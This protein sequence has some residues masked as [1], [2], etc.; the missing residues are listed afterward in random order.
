MSSS[1]QS[2]DPKEAKAPNEASL[3]FLRSLSDRLAPMLSTTV[4]LSQEQL[5]DLGVECTKLDF[6]TGEPTDGGPKFLHLAPVNRMEAIAETDNLVQKSIVRTETEDVDKDNYIT[7]EAVASFFV[8]S[9]FNSVLKKDNPD[10]PN[11]IEESPW[12]VNYRYH[13]STTGTCWGT[14]FTLEVRDKSKPDISCFLRNENLLSND[15]IFVAE[16]WVFVRLSI[17]QLMQKKY[18]DHQTVPVTITSA[19]GRSLRVLQSYV[20]ISNRRVIV[21]KSAIVELNGDDKE[22]LL[23]LLKAS[24]WFVGQPTREE[25]SH[26]A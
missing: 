17:K 18:H 15:K 12:S 19:S 22:N 11:L 7:A 23:K 16:L 13:Y 4:Y 3:D 24:R 21:R 8:H 5:K 10:E 6:D 1:S 14:C 9:I 25:P 20:D 26:L 2:K